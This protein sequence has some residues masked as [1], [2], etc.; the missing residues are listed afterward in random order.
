MRHF[1]APIRRNMNKGNMGQIHNK[2]L[3]TLPSKMIFD[4]TRL[5]VMKT[6]PIL[7]FFQKISHNQPLLGCDIIVK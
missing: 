1:S 4:P 7:T 2:N 6:K 3:I 5:I